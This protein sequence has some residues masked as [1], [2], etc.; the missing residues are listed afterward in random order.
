MSIVQIIGQQ[1]SGKT[2]LVANLVRHYNN[3]SFA[4]ATLKHTSH[5]YELDKPGKDSYIHRHS[6]ANPAGIVTSKMAALFFPI[7]DMAK[8][9]LLIQKYFSHADIILIEGW[10]SGPYPKIEV[11]RRSVGKP[12][13][14][15]NLPSVKALACNYEPDVVDGHTIDILDLDRIKNIADYILN[16]N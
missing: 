12:P 1:G 14:F 13:L 5:D 2:T 3:N 4:V 11:W 9:D 7:S 16:M 6:G 10:L 15:P 8:P